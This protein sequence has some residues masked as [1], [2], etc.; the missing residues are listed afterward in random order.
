MS[1]FLAFIV[2]ITKAHS[3]WFLLALAN[4]FR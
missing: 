2:I 4:E 3:A 1:R